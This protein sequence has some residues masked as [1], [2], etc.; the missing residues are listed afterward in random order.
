MEQSFAFVDGG[1][2]FT[3]SVETLG[4]ARAE[5]WWWFQVSTDDHQRYAPFRAAPSDTADVVR[6]RI[7]AYYENLLARRAEPSRGLWPR[8]RVGMRP[9]AEPVPVTPA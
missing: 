6:Q 3:C 2:T 1:R 4:R 9:I 8:G 5:V 7:V